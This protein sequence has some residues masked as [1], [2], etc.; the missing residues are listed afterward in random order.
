MTETTSADAPAGGA[1]LPARRRFASLR[2]IGALILREMSTAYG[3]SPGGY[4]WTIVEPVAGLALLSFVFS[5][6]VRTPPLGST[7]FLFY[8]G[9]MLPFMAYGMI[10]QKIAMAI[11]FSKPLLAYPSVTFID[12]IAA[13]LLLETATQ[14]VV[15]LLIFTGII[16]ISGEAVSLDFGAIALATLMAVS[17]GA[18]VGLMNSFLGSMYPIW[19]TL[20][21]VLNRPLFII[22]GI[23]FLIDRFAEQYRDIL[24]WNP[25][26]HIIMVM[27][28][29]FY[30]T[31]D[32]VYA[33]PSYVFTCAVIPGVLGLLLLYRYHK[34]ILEI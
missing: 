19:N 6:L 2:S 5:Y 7:F 33:S 17:L 21:A 4:A 15:G 28:S 9:G 29:G 20:W 14:L 12:A 3:R 32:A 22:S 24:M 13:R 16:M 18:G 1:R 30:G 27:R 26:A 34:D 10:S 23:F 31:Y 11:Q 25:L 8:A